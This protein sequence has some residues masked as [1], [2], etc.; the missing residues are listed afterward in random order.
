LSLLLERKTKQTS[1]LETKTKILINRLKSQNLKAADNEG[2]K[3]FV[4]PE[5]EPYILRIQ[6]A[7]ART[8][9]SIDIASSS[10]LPQGVFLMREE[11]ARATNRGVKIRCL[12][13][14]HESYDAKLEAFGDLPENP[15]FEIR[16][17]Q[18][19]SR[20]TFLHLRQ[21]RIVYSALA[22]RG[23]RQVSPSVDELSQHSG[24][25]STTF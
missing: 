9:K 14:I 6:K 5:G 23:F 16:G 11:L 22:H 24:S 19:H 13:G 4:V 25:I 17:I 12:T 15:A 21:R 10:N 2:P 18:V 7:I 1:D 8:Q 3:L 20:A